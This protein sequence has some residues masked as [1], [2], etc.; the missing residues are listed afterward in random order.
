MKK[1][2]SYSI[3]LTTVTSVALIGYCLQ[4]PEIDPLEQHYIEK[5]GSPI[6][7]P[8]AKNSLS[9]DNF[10]KDIEHILVFGITNETLILEITSDQEEF[11]E[12]SNIFSGYEL[13][14]LDYKTYPEGRGK[15][16]DSG[17]RILFLEDENY[18]IENDESLHPDYSTTT[19]IASTHDEY[20][21]GYEFNG[22]SNVLSIGSDTE[23]PYI[24]QETGKDIIEDLQVFAEKYPQFT[25]AALK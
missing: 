20:V 1:I 6:K 18:R 14:P 24:L 13:Q 12:L 8:I 4:K 2:L 10:E 7:T 11:L 23:M 19:V 9:L 25:R 17:E 5:Y 21:K 15:Y 16:F 22:T 3:L